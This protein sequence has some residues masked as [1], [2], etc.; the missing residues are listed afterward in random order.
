[1]ENKG[2]FGINTDANK[3]ITNMKAPESLLASILL[4][5]LNLEIPRNFAYKTEVDR[6]VVFDAN[7]R[8]KTME[9]IIRSLSS[10]K[11]ASMFGQMRSGNHANYAIRGGESVRLGMV[12]YD[13]SGN[14]RGHPRKKDLS[15]CI[16]VFLVRTSYSYI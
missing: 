3:D 2:R 10:I 9:E 7:Q 13:Y 1:M 16:P 14:F 11:D 12:A 4:K 8:P 5:G 6:Q 15:L